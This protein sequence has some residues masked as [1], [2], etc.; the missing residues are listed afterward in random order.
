[1]SC[2]RGWNGRA[3]NMHRSAVMPSGS[4]I[5]RE[6]L[7]LPGPGQEVAD[8]LGGMVGQT[9]EDVGEPSLRVDAMELA[10]FHQGVDRRGPLATTIR[11]GKGPIPAPDGHTAQ[12]SL[13]GVVAHAQA[14]IL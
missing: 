3:R 10:G 13:D 7:R 12:R 14:P 9:G 11:T 4:D 1:M 2:P 5:R 6:P 8:P